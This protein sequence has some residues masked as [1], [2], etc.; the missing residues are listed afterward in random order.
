MKDY[1]HKIWLKKIHLDKGLYNTLVSQILNYIKLETIIDRILRSHSFNRSSSLI[2]MLQE[3]QEE[4]GY[5]SEKALRLI[6]D[7]TGVS[8]SRVYGVATF[9]N[10]FRLN[11]EGKHRITVC[12]GTAC[13]MAR[14]I[15]IYNWLI[16][17]LHIKPPSDTSD[18]GLF[19]VKKANCLGA[20]SLA[21]VMRIDETFYREL[22]HEKLRSILDKIR[23]DEK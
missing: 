3:I 5:L 15:N 8:P 10:Q 18:D 17:E 4:Q 21:P 7:K 16:N 14:S 13:H 22:T 11:P 9:F 2:P 19:T 12:N 1:E 20:C 6:S 23:E